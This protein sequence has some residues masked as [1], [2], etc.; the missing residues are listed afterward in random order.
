MSQLEAEKPFRILSLDGGGSLGVYSLGVLTEI[1]A[2]LAPQPL[3][4]ALDLIYGTSTGS[5]IGSLIALKKPVDEI[6]KHYLK[7][8]VCAAGR[9]RHEMGRQPTT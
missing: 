2:M 5:I 3:H 4:E 9:L 1:E 8:G 7:L 6:R